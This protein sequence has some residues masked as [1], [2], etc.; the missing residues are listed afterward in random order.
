MSPT[1]VVTASAERARI[2][3]VWRPGAPGPDEAA[4]DEA[5]REH[6]ARDRAA[7]AAMVAA[8]GPGTRL[9]RAAPIADA[10]AD[11][12]AR[13]WIADDAL[14]LTRDPIGH[15][16]IF[17][18]PLPDGGVVFASAIHG[19][20]AS[21][22]VPR[23][24]EPAL[25]AWFL[26]YAYVPGGRTLARHVRALEPG[27]ELV[28]DRHSARLRRFWS[29]PDAPERWDEEANL[30]TRLRAT[31]EDAVSR[32]LADGPVGASLSGGIDSSLVLALARRAHPGPLSCYSVS[33]GSGHA[34][35]L[36]WS[37]L[38]ARHLGVTH[39]VVEVSAA[40]VAARFDATVSAMSMPNGDPLTVPNSMI[41]ERAARDTRFLLNGEGGDPCFGGPKN[42]PMILAELLGDGAGAS[43]EVSYLRAHQR[44]WDDL[45]AMLGPRVRGA[46]DPGELE[47]YVGTW[48]ARPGLLDPLMAINV[49]F[50]GGFHI[51]PKVDAL[52]APWGVRPRSPLFDARVV[53]LS[54]AIP[55]TLKRR[56]AI[57]KYL[58]K[59]SVRD[60][61]P[62]AV[63]DRP[64]S[65]MMVPVEAWFA[66]PLLPFARERLLDRSTLHGLVDRAWMERLIAGKG[67]GLRP[68]RGIKLWLLLTLEAWLRTVL[69]E[70]GRW[71]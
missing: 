39:N 71:S 26:T 4:R 16:S 6:T 68:R 10:D 32:H 56:G 21:G 48:L 69:R 55:P 53:E 51:L 58:L 52:A 22:L 31:L 37:G 38:V 41:F 28:V 29:L 17:W 62:D 50:K 43:R 49:A 57:E 65:G 13:A 19:V 8:L 61:L 36:E 42:G 35:E 20:L 30:R 14:H 59:E 18:A 46:L 54:F 33:F 25:V 27:E 66:G 5:A 7:E 70:D 1:A 64:K 9:L 67:L 23:A 63:I 11:G 24:L 34:N 47:R 40:D 2:A 60:L 3:G 44:C 12:Y 15:R 45:G